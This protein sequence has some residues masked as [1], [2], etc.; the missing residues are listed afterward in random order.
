MLTIDSIILYVEDI[1]ISQRFYETVLTCKASERSPSFVSF[2]LEH[3]TML[4]LKQRDNALPYSDIKGGGAELSIAVNNQET[5]MA[6][7]HN[8][9]SQGIPF[10]QTLTR[11]IFG[12]TFVIVDPD[13]HRIRVFVEDDITAK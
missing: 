8:W 4:E 10:I 9:H 6:L 7:Y 1:Q 2:N 3:S 12:I 13:N 5:L 11:L